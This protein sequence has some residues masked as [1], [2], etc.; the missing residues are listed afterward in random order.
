M[1]ES[2]KHPELS[3]YLLPGHTQ[4]PVDAIAEAQQANLEMKRLDMKRQ[5]LAERQQH[6][7]IRSPISGTVVSGDIEKSEGAPLAIGQNLFEIFLI[8]FV[9]R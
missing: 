3:C 5:L 1:N 7:Q 9:F 6:L 4:T 2:P 8:F